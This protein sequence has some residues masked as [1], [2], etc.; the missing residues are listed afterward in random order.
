MSK[1]KHINLKNLIYLTGLM[2]P[3][4]C[5]CAGVLDNLLESLMSSES[6][7]SSEFRK[8]RKGENFNR[9]THRN[10][11]FSFRIYQWKTAGMKYASI[12]GVDKTL[13]TGQHGS[14]RRGAYIYYYLATP[15]GQEL[16]K[17]WVA[18]AADNSQQVYVPI[19]CEP[20]CFNGLIYIGITSWPWSVRYR[21]HIQKARSG[22]HLP[23]HTAIREQFG[24]YNTRFHYVLWVAPTKELA[25]SAEELYVEQRSL[26]PK[27]LNAIPGG[28]A[29]L[30][31][32]A[33]IN[34]FR[35]NGDSELFTAEDVLIEILSETSNVQS[36][37]IL[38][39]LARI[40]N[41]A[42]RTSN[43][44]TRPEMTSF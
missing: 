2:E 8:W 19:P 6:E 37:D 31:Y 17:R 33:S 16:I 18:G 11:N 44:N 5:S 40:P 15:E 4:A 14:A 38:K 1:L 24:S 21:E 9:F 35:R 26:Y 27:G 13:T 30:R 32:L 34:F 3:L 23:F 36:N 10:T 29:G 41:A 42:E 22:S 43:I 7:Q 12:C 28:K 25:E 20:H 39:K